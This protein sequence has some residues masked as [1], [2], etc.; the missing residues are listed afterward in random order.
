MLGRPLISARVAALRVALAAAATCAPALRADARTGR[1]DRIYERDGR[2]VIKVRVFSLPDPSNTSTINRA[3]VA[4]VR[5][6][7]ERFPGIF[8]KRYRAR[9]EADPAK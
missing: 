4:G 7:K 8:A 2:T 1:S 3:E 6:F 5:A 9:Y